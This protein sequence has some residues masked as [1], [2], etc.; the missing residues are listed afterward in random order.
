MKQIQQK[1][2]DKNL[3][4]KNK[5]EG[6]VKWGAEKIVYLHLFN[7][8]IKV[9]ENNRSHMKG[10]VWIILLYINLSVYFRKFS[11]KVQYWRFEID[12]EVRRSFQIE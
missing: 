12:R 2:Y 9:F 4:M 8:N 5:S 7:D 6:I 3:K 11:G 10:Y 1:C